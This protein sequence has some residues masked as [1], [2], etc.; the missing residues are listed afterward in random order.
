M[1]VSPCQCTIQQSACSI[2]HLTIGGIVA[3]VEYIFHLLEPS[4]QSNSSFSSFDVA[5]LS[6]Q[7]FLVGT[8][9]S[10]V[11]NSFYTSTSS[12]R[13]SIS[14]VLVC[15]KVIMEY[16]VKIR[17]KARILELKR[18]HLKKLILTSYTPYPSRK[19]RHICTCTSQETTKI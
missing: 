19:I 3:D 8:T 11:H 12:L 7:E 13:C 14:M 18:R 2:L 1:G 15:L 17:K 16:L 5:R 10:G 6:V 4:C 9:T